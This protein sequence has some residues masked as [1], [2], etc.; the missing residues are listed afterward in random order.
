MGDAAQ[1]RPDP[2]TSI[3]HGI[4]RA[5]TE[6]RADADDIEVARQ[7]GRESLAEAKQPVVASGQ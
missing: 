5:H 4:D 2:V 7:L 3:D 6:A 1:Q